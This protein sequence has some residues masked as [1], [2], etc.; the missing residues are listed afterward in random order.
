[1]H[2]ESFPGILVCVEDEASG[3]DLDVTVL[4]GPNVWDLRR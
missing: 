3:L 2:R 1:V 4:E